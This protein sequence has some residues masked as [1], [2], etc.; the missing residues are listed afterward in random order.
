MNASCRPNGPSRRGFLSGS[1]AALLAGTGATLVPAVPA[2]AEDSYATLRQR[3]RDQYTGGTGIDTAD[4]AIAAA[5]EAI[6]D[7]ARALRATLV[8]DPER[9]FL[10][11]DLDFSGSDD[12]YSID[13]RLSYERLHQLAIAQAAPGNTGDPAL[14]EEI[15][16]G[17]DWMYANVYNEHVPRTGNWF[18]WQIGAPLALIGA[19]ML[20]YDALSATQRENSM[21]AVGHWTPRPFWTGANRVWSCL[22]V[23]GRGALVDDGDALAAASAG[24]GPVFA[25]TTTGDGF[26]TDGSFIQHGQ[27]A[28][29]GG[30]GVPLLLNMARTLALLHDSPWQ[31]SDAR[32]VNVYDWVPKTYQPWLFRGSMMSPVRG[33]NIARHNQQD[34]TSGHDAIR[35][36][37]WLAGVAPDDHAPAMRALVKETVEADTFADVLE[38]SYGNTVPGNDLGSIAREL[39][40][41]AGAHPQAQP[42]TGTTLFPDMDRMVHQRPGFAFA[43]AMSSTRIA[44]Y[45]SISAQN[46]HGWYTG[47]G[48]QY[49]YNADLTHYDDGYWAT[50]DPY[51]L[52]GTTVPVTP[53]PDASGN[54]RRTPYSWVGGTAHSG[55]GMTGMRFRS[56]APLAFRRSR[57]RLVSDGET[58]TAS[59]S[60]DGDTYVRVG[61]PAPI[62]A[63]TDPGLGVYAARGLADAPTIEARFAEFS[64]TCA[65]GSCAGASD[66]FDGSTLDTTRWTRI[67]REDPDRYWLDE[68]SLVLPTAR[69]EFDKGDDSTRNIILQTAPT[70]AWSAEVVLDLQ[71]R[72]NYQHAGIVLY[73]DDRNYIRI[74]RLHGGGGDRFTFVAMV[75]G[76]RTHQAHSFPADEVDA[77]LLS[78]APSGVK[79]W[80]TV[81][82]RIVALGAGISASSE[83]LVETAIENRKIS[84]A[85]RLVIDD[86]EQPAHDGAET[87]VE[88]AAWAHL[89]GPSPSADIGYVF[90]HGMRLHARR[91]VRTHAWSEINKRASFIDDTLFDREYLTL[92]TDHGIDPTT[93]S[94]MFTLLPGASRQQVLEYSR[95]PGAQVVANTR[96]VQAVRAGG[97]LGANFWTGSALDQLTCSGPASVLVVRDGGRLD[98]AVSDPS[99]TATQPLRVTYRQSVSAA[100]QVPENVTVRELTPRVVLEVDLSGTRGRTSVV[101]F[102]LAGARA[103]PRSD[104]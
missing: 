57:L 29:T 87:T 101:S 84:T 15:L 55:V 86:V 14:A 97:V 40:I 79:S 71:P 58:V 44:T 72:V 43:V 53:L 80:F 13:M 49:L 33:R 27:Y 96:D 35:G 3:W 11:P 42:A 37:A 28:Y 26:H 50:V 70:G 1:A 47:D 100:T 62:G 95:N 66:T 22:V 30:Y 25:Y 94:Y 18:N 6:H 92:W 69:G 60:P 74:Q 36:I 31:V 7:D 64:L 34:H 39:E 9:S 65:D 89:S 12:D 75:N 99:R 98:I 61:Q 76:A 8:L 102:R 5:L 90:G 81:D 17:L 20:M 67:V 38:Y 24:L 46:L 23:A 85:Q 51:R 63:L 16:A 41:V 77:D 88:N 93:A 82:D 45:E 54:N 2:H 56:N 19:T 78:G 83:H 21:N 59:W 48:M 103:V 91:E 104:D 4:P 73:S 32:V 10:W 68:G 52:P